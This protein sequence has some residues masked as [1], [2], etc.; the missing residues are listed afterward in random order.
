VVVVAS[1]GECNGVVGWRYV[2]AKVDVGIC[3]C[4]GDRM[5]RVAEVGSTSNNA[6]CHGKLVI[7]A[8]IM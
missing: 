4:E 1:L 5:A 2:S 3:D 8:T 7:A 6:A